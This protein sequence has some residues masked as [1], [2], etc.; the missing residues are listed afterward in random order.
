M[1]TAQYLNSG[2]LP[3][4]SRASL[5]RALAAASRKWKGMKMGPGAMRR[6][7]W[8]RGGVGRPGAGPARHDARV[9]VL[10][11]PARV[12]DEGV[13]RVRDL[14]RGAVLA[15]D[16]LPAAARGGEAVAEEELDAIAP[17]G[18]GAGPQFAVGL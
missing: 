18:V 11:E 10:E 5:V 16:E 9:P 13:L 15:G 12:E 8:G 3:K 6:G 14:G 7:A 17:L 4:G 2:I 1:R